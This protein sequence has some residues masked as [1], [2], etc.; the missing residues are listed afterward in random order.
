MQESGYVAQAVLIL[1]AL[2]CIILASIYKSPVLGLLDC[3][4]NYR[5]IYKQMLINYNCITSSVNYVVVPESVLRN[6]NYSLLS[7]TVGF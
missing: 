3:C 6:K 2:L 5:L 7:I 1:T 4:H